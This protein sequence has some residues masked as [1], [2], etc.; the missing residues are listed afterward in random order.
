MLDVHNNLSSIIS[1]STTEIN[2]NITLKAF[3]FLHIPIM[4]QIL[5]KSITV[6]TENKLL[7]KSDSLLTYSMVE[8]C[9]FLNRKSN[10]LD[11]NNNLARIILVTN[12]DM[13]SKLLLKADIEKPILS[14]SYIFYYPKRV[15]QKGIFETL[16]NSKLLLKADIE[17]TYTRSQLDTQ[18][19]AKSNN[20]DTYNRLLLKSDT[21]FTYSKLE[22]DN[23]LNK[24]S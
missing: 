8:T 12:N 21:L 22:S 24:K 13:N 9:N 3:V 14:M 15:H 5:S 2:D 1:V 17:T 19:L 20:T 18:L 23:L 4:K 10:I 7:V 11:V 6:E 16:N